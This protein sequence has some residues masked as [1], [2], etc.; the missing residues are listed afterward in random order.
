MNTIIINTMKKRIFVLALGMAVVAAFGWCHG[1]GCRNGDRET[2]HEAA[3]KGDLESMKRLME[4]VNVNEK[5]ELGGLT[6]LH[7]AAW[8]GHLKIVKLLVKNG[9]NVNEKDGYGCTALHFAALDGH[10]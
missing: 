3:R 10:L 8:N 5:A 4:T 7:V 1:M 9:A 6:A 2:L